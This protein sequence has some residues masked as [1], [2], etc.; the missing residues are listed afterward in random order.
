MSE[1]FDLISLIFFF[2]G[3]AIISGG[4]TGSPGKAKHP[5]ILI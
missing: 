1:S 3:D 5:R 2:S 4:F